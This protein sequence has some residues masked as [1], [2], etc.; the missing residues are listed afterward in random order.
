MDKSKY[1]RLAL[2]ASKKQSSKVISP[3]MLNQC[4]EKQPLLCFIVLTLEAM[5]HHFFIVKGSLYLFFLKKG[6]HWEGKMKIGTCFKEKE[7]WRCICNSSCSWL[8]IVLHQLHRVFMVFFFSDCQF[9]SFLLCFVLTRA[10]F[11]N[12]P[13]IFLSAGVADSFFD[14][15]FIL[16]S[17]LVFFF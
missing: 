1:G 15:F 4:Y 8:L 10:Y 14:I 12:L 9:F 11:R 7:S 17:F 6:P 16:S 3:C 2:I 5:R 13:Q